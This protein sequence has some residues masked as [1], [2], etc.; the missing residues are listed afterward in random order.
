MVAANPYALMY[1][2]LAL[3]QSGRRVPLVV[4]FHTTLLGNA[5]EWLK[6]L[7]YRPFFWSADC[8]V[9]LCEAQRRHWLRRW[10]RRARTA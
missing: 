8:L 1:C 9:F 5:R 4:T 2:A 3:R 10:S 6:M 7:Y